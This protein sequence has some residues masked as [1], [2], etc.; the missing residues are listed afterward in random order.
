MPK[1]AELVVEEHTGEWMAEL[2]L[3]GECEMGA[4]GADL[5]GLERLVVR[6]GALPKCGNLTLRSE[7]GG[8]V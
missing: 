3:A 7:R 2:E 4:G 8:G 5:P 1:L 6:D